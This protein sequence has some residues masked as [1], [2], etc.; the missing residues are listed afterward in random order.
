MERDKEIL[1]IKAMDLA[2]KVGKFATMQVPNTAEGAFIAV[3]ALT[4]CLSRLCDTLEHQFPKKDYPKID[5]N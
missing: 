1:E 3:R 2:F 4:L 5:H